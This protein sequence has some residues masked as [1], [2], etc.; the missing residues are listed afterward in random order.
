MPI[1]SKTEILRGI[2]KTYR[3][4]SG[5]AYET[6]EIYFGTDEQGRK[7]RT[8]RPSKAEAVKYVDDYFRA[9][10]TNGCLMTALRPKDV[11][12]ARE[13]RD[14]LNIA[15]FGDVTLR[16]CAREFIGREGTPAARDGRQAAARDMT[17]GAAYAEY[18][19]SIP[20]ECE[21]QIKCVE[22][23]VKRW[24]DAI[25]SDRSLSDVTAKG[26]SDYVAAMGVA[27]KTRNNHRGYIKSFLSWCAADERRYIPSN[28]CSGMKL[29]REPYKEPKFI[30]AED[31]E[32]LAREVEGKHPEAIPYM[33]LSYWCG[34]RTAEIQRL[35]ETPEDIRI[36][37][38][39]VRITKVKGWTGGRRPRIVH[40]EP[41][42]KEWMRR[43][44]VCGAIGKMTVNA[45]Q[46]LVYHAAEDAGVKLGHNMGRHSYITHLSAKTGDPRRAEGM[47]G[48]SSGMRTKNYDGLA[49]KTE[50]EAY[51]AIMPS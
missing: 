23:R 8:V 29:E 1:R 10:E 6:W 3:A 11:M 30:S 9:L 20:R 19:A 27:V 38:E 7:V 32:K 36:D 25:G 17:V 42:A 21:M 15:G 48:T 44:G 26:V 14:M 31:M 4:V 5:K 37:E 39:T 24:V 40:I 47:A 2:K 41:N 49:T 43:Y 51:F 34:I 50:G 12:D 45:Q 33:V 28:P 16:Q 35:A 18:L 22:G 13:A 46:K